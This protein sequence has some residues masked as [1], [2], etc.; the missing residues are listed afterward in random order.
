MHCCKKKKNC[1]QINSVAYARLKTD[2]QFNVFI[3]VSINVHTVCCVSER[4]SC[5]FR[6]LNTFIYV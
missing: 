1:P 5:L 6:F 2:G 4:A 3:L